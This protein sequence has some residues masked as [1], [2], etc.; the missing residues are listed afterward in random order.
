MSRR[1][2]MLGALAHV[3]VVPRFAQAQTQDPTPTS[4]DIPTLEA[5]P[6]DDPAPLPAPQADSYMEEGKVSYYAR[7]FS[8]RKTANGE[9]FNPKALTMAH[10][11]L[12]FGTRVQVTNLGNGRSVVVRVNDRGPRHADRVADLSLAA[13]QAIGMGKQGIVV[14]RLEI[15]MPT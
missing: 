3:V 9:R 6:S 1:R 11:T 5:T 2:F 4:T 7:F 10:K 12:S 15:L 13:A 14:A 8:G